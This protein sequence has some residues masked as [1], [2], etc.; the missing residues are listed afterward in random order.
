MPLNSSPATPLQCQSEVCSL[1]CCTAC[2]LYY[3][4]QREMM[5]GYCDCAER[6][7]AVASWSAEVL[8]DER[9]VHQLHLEFHLART[10]QNAGAKGCVSSPEPDQPLGS[11]VVA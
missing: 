6:Q 4:I 9:E 2:T 11:V 3:E 1:C 8:M 10:E 5:K 7:S